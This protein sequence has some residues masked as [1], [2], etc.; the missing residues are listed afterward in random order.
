VQL[1]VCLEMQRSGAKRTSDGDL[2]DFC[3]QEWPR[4][5]G[6]LSLYTGDPGLA[7][8]LAQ[9]TIAR[10]CQHWRRVRQLDAPGAWAHR[11]AVNL[12][13]SHFRRRRVAERHDVRQA[14]SESV[15][16][17]GGIASAV[18][19][20]AAIARLPH[21]QQVALVARYYLDLPVRAVAL[22]LRCPEGTVKTLTHRAIAN[23]RAAHLINDV[24]LEMQNDE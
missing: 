12:A 15:D 10:V 6:A 22:I 4:L 14:N 18:A 13:H 24:E 9:E 21:R 8:D 3:R 16:S 7:E 19:V 5:V 23:L 20:R 11:V 2:D 17:L 1:G